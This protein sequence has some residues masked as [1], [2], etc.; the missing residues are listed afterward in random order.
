MGSGGSGILGGVGANVMGDLAENTVGNLSN[1]FLG[2]SSSNIMGNLAGSVTSNIMKGKGSTGIVNSLVNASGSLSN[3]NDLTTGLA[4]NLAKG[5][6][7]NAGSGGIAKALSKT[8]SKGL[9]GNLGKAYSTIGSISSPGAIVSNLT[10][11]DS[12]ANIVGLHSM[13]DLLG[14]SSGFV[15]G[16]LK[17]AAITGSSLLKGE[18][19]SSDAMSQ[20]KSVASTIN[21]NKYSTGKV[22][23]DGG[24]AGLGNGV[25]AGKLGTAI[26][27]FLGG[28]NGSKVGKVVAESLTPEEIGSAVFNNYGSKA[29]LLLKPSTKEKMYSELKRNNLLRNGVSSSSETREIPEKYPADLVSE[30]L[31]TKTNSAS[32]ISTMGSINDLFT[33]MS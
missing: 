2:S 5:V 29:D 16:N 19:V 9:T 27:K 33:G 13:G 24:F 6:L 32:G 18:S 23:G 30:Y 10:S 22:S 20:M 1:K 3:S 26:G 7:T 12:S 14:K 21:R 28:A 25:T 31:K 17:T 4:G 8:V 15:Q 11:N